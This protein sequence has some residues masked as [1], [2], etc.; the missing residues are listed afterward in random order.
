MGSGSSL[1]VLVSALLFVYLWKV[2]RP[3]RAD[4]R[5]WILRP[6]RTTGSGPTDP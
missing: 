6:D 4:D 2:D 5:A 3:D 1:S